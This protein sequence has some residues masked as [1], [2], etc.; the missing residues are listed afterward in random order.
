MEEKELNKIEEEI[1]DKVKDKVQ[2]TSKKETGSIIENEVRKRNYLSEDWQIQYAV[3]RVREMK[4]QFKDT[5]SKKWM[6]AKEQELE[7]PPQKVKSWRYKKISRKEAVQTILWTGLALV[8]LNLFGVQGGLL[9]IILGLIA[10]VASIIWLIKTIKL[11]LLK[12][13]IK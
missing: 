3:G 4:K 11:K 5:E 1:F 12:K 6:L 10:T 9:E 7:G 13:L 8:I 2:N